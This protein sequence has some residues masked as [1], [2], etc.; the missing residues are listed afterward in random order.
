MSEAAVIIVGGC[1]ALGAFEFALGWY[2]GSRR[3]R[4]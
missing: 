1:F 3:G 2:V 4:K